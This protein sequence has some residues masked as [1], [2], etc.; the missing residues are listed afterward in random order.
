MPTSGVTRNAG[1]APLLFTRGRAMLFA[2]GVIALAA[3][4]AYHNSFSVPFVFDDSLAI[5]ANPTIRRLWPVWP[6]LSP[7]DHLSVGGRP[8]ANLT[9][10]LNYAWGG[11]DVRGYHAVNLAIH[12]LAGLT[13]LGVVRRTLRFHWGRAQPDE[14]SWLPAFFVA[15]LWTVHPLQ[16]EAVTYVIQ[17]TE[18]LMGLF[19]LLTLYGFIRAVDSPKPWFWQTLSIAACLLG[20][21]SKEVM[22]A[23]P[24]V[25]LL[26]DRTFVSGSVREAWRQRRPYYGLLATTWLLLGCL[27]IHTGSRGGTAGFGTTVTWWLYALT[28]CGAIVRY[29]QLALWPHPLV[30]DYG[31]SLTGAAAEIVPDALIVGALAAGT[32][33]AFWRRPAIGFVGV[34]FFA[35]LAPTSSVVPVATQT[36][37]EHRMYL[38]LA[39]VIALLGTGLHAVLGRWR[40]GGPLILMAIALGFLTARRNDDYRSELA[41]W[42]DTAAKCPGNARAHFTLANVL[43]RQG[44]LPAAMLEYEETLRIDPGHAEAHNSLGNVLVRLGRRPEAIGRYEQ[45]LRLESDYVE[46]RYNLGNAL[47]Q[48]GRLSEALPHYERALR[49]DPENAEAHNNLGNALLLMGRTTEAAAEYEQALHFQPGYAEAHY[50]LGNALAQLGRLS[51][52]AEHYEQALHLKPDYREAQENLRRVHL[53]PQTNP[54]GN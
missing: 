48:A 31:K 22:V 33:V 30:L 36:M 40:G 14:N 35:V 54:A 46:A 24:L 28:Q 13:L 11:T 7:P 12:I 26:H 44:A 52:A 32:A 37:A 5:T 6:A 23:A 45:A 39:A 47:V 49:A 25:V 19:F 17:R 29:L 10:A 34:C 20:M 50:N 27:V 9:L 3:L 2:G 51:E 1:G 41:I 21:A 18:S 53:L 38:P 8:M 4:A 43:Y 15:L 16:T 42:H